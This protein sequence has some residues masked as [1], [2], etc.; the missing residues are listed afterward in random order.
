ME[1]QIKIEDCTDLQLADAGSQAY[2]QFLRAQQQLI[3]VNSEINKRKNAIGNIPIS[4]TAK[5]D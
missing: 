1:K 2:E 4:S 5:S 3:V